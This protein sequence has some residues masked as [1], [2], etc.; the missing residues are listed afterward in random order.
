M[1]YLV[2][3]GAARSGTTLIQQILNTHSSVACF[4][5]YGMEKLENYVDALFAEER[6]RSAK[7]ESLEEN[8]RIDPCV[9]ISSSSQQEYCPQ[10]ASGVIEDNLYPIPQRN[11]DFHNIVKAIYSACFKKNDL[12]VVGDKVTNIIDKKYLDNL[13]RI[14]EGIV[15]I[16]IL[17]HPFDVVRSSMVRAK[18]AAIGKDIWHVQT[19]DEAIEEWVENLEFAAS[20]REKSDAIFFKY[21]DLYVNFDKEMERL[22]EKL[23]I[24][25]KFKNIVVP[26]DRPE[27]GFAMTSMQRRYIT[28]R[29]GPLADIWSSTN[30]ET[31]LKDYSVLPFRVSSGDVININNGMLSR[32]TREGF[33]GAENWGVWTDGVHARIVLIIKDARES[34]N[35]WMD[36]S[37]I[38]FV[39]PIG[40]FVFGVKV[41]DSKLEIIENSAEYATSY[42]ANLGRMY[43]VKNGLV[44]I[45]FSIPR[46]KKASYEPSGDTRA[47]GLG[48]IS[49]C[50]TVM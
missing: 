42:S 7:S 47:I 5:E 29:V 46:P 26:F 36:L 33:C 45:L 34:E 32:V 41:N 25:N 40:N 24:E 35:I 22:A 13:R 1:K 10:D 2:V 16:F 39:G 21:E 49:L 18:N 9:E 50:V 27:G 8:R 6:I 28:D 44:E 11:R 12:L 15:T 19:I 31:I 17:R 20:Q 38:G 37:Y 48:I 3:M 23:G 43:V 30:V 14:Y 4:H